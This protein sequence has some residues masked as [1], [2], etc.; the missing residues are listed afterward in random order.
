FSTG[1]YF[2]VGIGGS[3]KH[4]YTY[5]ENGREVSSKRLFDES[6]YKLKPVYGKVD[7]ELYEEFME[8]NQ[9]YELYRAFDF[10]LN[11]GLGYEFEGFLFNIGYSL[12]LVN[13]NP[14]YEPGIFS[15]N[16]YAP[17]V[18][19]DIFT[20]NFVKKNRVFTFSVAYLFN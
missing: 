7:Q 9:L 15:N 16:W 20:E 8:D 4:D 2:A 19:S 12:G 17:D 10:G 1:P 6:S 13:L 5:E 11:F 14:D 3:L 18:D